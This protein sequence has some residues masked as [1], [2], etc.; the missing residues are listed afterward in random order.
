MLARELG[1]PDAEVEL[2]EQAA[3]L[4]D[5]GKITIPDALLLKPGRLTS[6]EYEQIKE[7]SIAGA[8]IL[9]GSKSAVLQLARDIALTHHEWWDGSG[10]PSGLRGEEIPLAGRIVG[11]VDVFDA[12][13]HDRP[14]KPPWAYAEALAEIHRLSG[15]Q[16]DP[17]IVGAFMRVFG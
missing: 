7:H 8:S 14:Y 16:F 2:I 4:H 6:G 9:A 13:T 5:L 3:P 15:T 10:Y 17:R 12:L 11:I 1:L